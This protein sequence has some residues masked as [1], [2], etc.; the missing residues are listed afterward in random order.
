MTGAL[1][2]ILAIS[3]LNFLM[4]TLLYLSLQDPGSL[5]L[6]V[7]GNFEDVCC[8]DPIVL[9]ASHYMAASD[10]EL[11]DGDLQDFSRWSPR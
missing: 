1:T 10:T 3:A 5:W 9:T 2:L 4:Y 11:K 6:V 8:I 7:I